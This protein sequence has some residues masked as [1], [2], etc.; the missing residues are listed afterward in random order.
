MENSAPISPDASSHPTALQ[1]GIDLAADII[2]GTAIPAPVKR[3]ALKA[4]DR[5]CTAA[6]ENRI[7]LINKAGDQIAEQMY[8][9]PEYTKA[10]VR[11]F[12]HKVIREQINLDR[13]AEGAA[14]EIKDNPPESTPQEIKSI[15]DDWLNT[16]EKE[17]AQK[18]T[19][20]MQRMFSRI[21]AGE[22]K[23][24]SS[25]SIKTIKLLAE[26]DQETATLFRQF[27]SACVTLGVPRSNVV[28]DARVPSLGGN[29]GTNSL[30]EYGFNFG[31]LNV[32][33]EHGLIISD[34]NSWMEY[35]HAIAQRAEGRLQVTLPI[36]FQ[37]KYWALV[38]LADRNPADPLQIHGVA[39]TKT[40]QQIASIIELPENDKFREALT[41]YFASQKL[42]MMEVPA[43]KNKP[44]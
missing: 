38:P 18:S 9:D 14:K 36:L 4:F 40:G 16:F 21:L 25:F 6:I 43:Q 31:A 34:Y 8:I 42:G 23:R 26:L 32:L 27:C 29:A 17:A 11:K 39:L 44:M 15:D 3:N 2:S 28:L 37:R 22:I 12:G 19:E 24:P 7:K 10:A 33:Q 20:D 5:L 13:I 41:K 1:K 35:Q 30:S